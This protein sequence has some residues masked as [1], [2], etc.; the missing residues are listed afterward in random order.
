MGDSSNMTSNVLQCRDV[1][2][3]IGSRQLFAS[4]ALDLSR[5]E[6]VAVVGPS[7]SGKSTLL[8]CISG[9]QLPTHGKICV[10]GDTL[11][12]IGDARRA[13]LRLHKMGIV[14]QSGDLLPELDVCQNV[15]LPGQ[16]R[17]M[18][19]R[20][21]MSQA[22]YYLH[23]VNLHGISHNHVAMLSGGEYQRVAIARALFGRP[24]LIIADEPTGALDEFNSVLISDLLIETAA[25]IGAGL[26]IATHDPVV[27]QRMDQKLDL[28]RMMPQ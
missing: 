26:V 12:E 22:E 6:S 21:A 25:S 17:G 1:G 7:G 28:R 23:M 8:N 11:T 2:V 9:M 4:L 10:G 18:S 24:L 14:T 16:L 15:A 19:R 5:G 3:E 13:N 20:E 27:Y